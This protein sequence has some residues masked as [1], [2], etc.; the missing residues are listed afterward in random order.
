[1]PNPNP[2]APAS[3]PPHQYRAAVITVSD[4]AFAGK[5]TDTSGPLV[6]EIAAAAGYTITRHEILPDDAP[7]LT[8]ALEHLCD[9]HLADLVLTTGGTGFSPRDIT[10]EATHAAAQRLAPG[11]AEAMRAGSLAYTK[12]AMLSRGIAALREKTLIINLP[13]SPKAARENLSCVISELRH[14][15]DILTGQ[16]HECGQ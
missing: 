11:I 13:G 7:R 16:T 9:N 6:C 12:R 10:P 1:M 5:R 15:L 4:S 14:G 3:E 8:A 2:R